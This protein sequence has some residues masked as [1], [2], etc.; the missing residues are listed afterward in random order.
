MNLMA[1]KEDSSSN[2]SSLLAA[3]DPGEDCLAERRA[4]ETSTTVVIIDR[5]PF[6]HLHGLYC[7][8]LC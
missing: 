7:N 1:Q 8:E 6:I 3:K 5:R 4:L 2:I